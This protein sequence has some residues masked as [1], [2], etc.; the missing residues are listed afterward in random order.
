MPLTTSQMMAREAY[1]RILAARPGDEYKSFAREFPSLVHTCGLAQSVA[2][3]LAK[4]GHQE[5]Y[6]HDL[7]KVLAAAGHG[8]VGEAQ[9]LA[10]QTRELSVTRYLRLSRNALAAAE[11]L[12]RYVEAYVQAT[13]K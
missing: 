11:W 10:K 3:A 9:R 12:K 7:A 4:G 2:F 8:E 13:E 6:A 1:A 5:K